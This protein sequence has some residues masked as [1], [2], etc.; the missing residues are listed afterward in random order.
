MIFSSLFF[1]HFFYSFCCFFVLFFFLYL[2]IQSTFRLPI[3][4]SI[5]I[6]PSLFPLCHSFSLS[7]LLHSSLLLPLIF[8]FT[9]SLITINHLLPFSLPS[10]SFS[11]SHV[12][13]FYI[14]N[15]CPKIL[16]PSSIIIFIL[17]LSLSLSL[18][19]FL[20]FLLPFFRK[21]DLRDVTKLFP[22]AFQYHQATVFFLAYYWSQNR[23]NLSPD[24]LRGDCV[25]LAAMVN[26]IE[27][28]RN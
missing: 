16:R 28:E 21:I 1:S 15:I 6:F 20:V 19:L 24:R 11:N 23:R 4:F 22:G 17:V 2:F 12:C 9:L 3:Y 5:F 14:I 8:F 7:P 18:L 26:F 25:S 27:I 10:F 13:F